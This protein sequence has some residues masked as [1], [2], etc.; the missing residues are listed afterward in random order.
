[1][2]RNIHYY[3]FYDKESNNIMFHQTNPFYRKL[4]QIYM[5]DT[6]K[7]EITTIIHDFIKYS[8]N[9]SQNNIPRSLRLILSGEEGIGKTTLLEAIATEYDYSI[10][11]F[12]KNN[13][14]EKM[15]HSFFSNINKLSMNNMI[16]FDN[17]DFN[18]IETYNKH[19]YELLAELIIKN[20]K[21]NIFIF[22]FNHLNNIPVIFTTSYHIHHH[23]HMDTNI[24]ILMNFIKDNLNQWSEDELD[25]NKLNEIKNKIIRIN[26]KITPGYIIPYLLFNEDFEKS[27]ARFFR[28]IRN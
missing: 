23:Y 11:H 22:T 19:L 8:D 10:I 15:I 14:S 6:V 21:K 27:L 20:D 18:A 13:Y 4:Q 26:H 7:K 9:F 25:L 16:V 1:M 24:S 28:V 5:S 17:I 12:P 3:A 2:S